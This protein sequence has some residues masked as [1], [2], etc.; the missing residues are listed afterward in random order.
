MCVK[1]SKVKEVSRSPSALNGEEA[2]YLF[3]SEVTTETLPCLRDV[4][5]DNLRVCGIGVKSSRRRFDFI[6]EAVHF[7]ASFALPSKK[8]AT[9]APV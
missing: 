1:P 9:L 4:G 8:A 5:G 3:A 7:A 2:V 6:G